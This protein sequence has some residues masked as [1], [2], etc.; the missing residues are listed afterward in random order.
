LLNGVED[1]VLRGDG[2]VDGDVD[3]RQALEVG[4]VV[5]DILHLKA[6]RQQTAAD[7]TQ[8]EEG[9]RQRDEKHT[10]G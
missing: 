10:I 9:K 1:V 5:G 4:Q 7:H 3:D 2:K 6:D 8:S